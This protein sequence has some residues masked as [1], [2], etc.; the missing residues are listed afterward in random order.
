M[1][2]RQINPFKCTLLSTLHTKRHGAHPLDGITTTTRQR[3]SATS[4]KIFRHCFLCVFVCRRV[5]PWERAKTVCKQLSARKFAP[6]R[7]QKID[8][9]TNGFFDLLFSQRRSSLLHFSVFIVCHFLCCHRPSP[10]RSFETTNIRIVQQ[11]MLNKLL[12][13]S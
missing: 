5:I 2:F 8:Y 3:Q 11:N 4:I 9:V 12:E 7:W 13:F 10:I 6:N 1:F